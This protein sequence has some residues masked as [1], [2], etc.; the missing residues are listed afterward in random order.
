MQWLYAITNDVPGKASASCNVF[1]ACASLA[2][3]AICPTKAEPCAM[4]CKARSFLPVGL[5]LTENLA[6]APIGVDF[7]RWKAHDP[8]LQNRCHKPIRRHLLSNEIS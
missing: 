2:P 5:P 6:L 7:G 8:S 3:N 4:A 1:N